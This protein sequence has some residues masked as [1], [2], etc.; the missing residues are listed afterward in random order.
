[1]PKLKTKKAAAKRFKSTASGLL[2]HSRTNH[3]HKTGKKSAKRK[4]RLRQMA[5]TDK[6]NSK[7]MH[8]ILPYL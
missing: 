6:T 8:K 1:M 4:M 2:K 5:V 3:Q 7:V